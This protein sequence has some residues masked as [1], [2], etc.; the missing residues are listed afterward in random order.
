MISRAGSTPYAMYT[1]RLEAPDATLFT[2]FTSCRFSSSR[3]T[4]RARHLTD[5]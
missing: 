1:L 2:A 4:W 5:A 3:S